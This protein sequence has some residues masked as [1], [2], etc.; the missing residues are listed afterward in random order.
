MSPAATPYV[1]IIRL[2]ETE[3]DGT[4]GVLKIN[5]T[6]F[7]HTLEPPDRENQRNR[8]SIP[9]QQY[10]AIEYDSPGYGKTFRVEAV[11]GRS[12]ILFHAG[13]ID[14]HTEGCIILGDR[15]GELSGRRAVLNSRNTMRRFMDALRGF[16]RFRL[17]VSECLY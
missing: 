14:D 7:C 5:G 4:F 12:H 16:D 6:L 13:N 17:S 8:S 3:G 10:T 1:Q 9:A 2:E 11:P 15:L